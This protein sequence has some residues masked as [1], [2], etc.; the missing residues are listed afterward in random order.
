MAHSSPTQTSSNTSV[1]CA[2]GRY[3]EYCGWRMEFCVH[4]WLVLSESSN[5]L[6]AMTLLPDYILV[7][8]SSTHSY[9][10]PA[11]M[12]ASQIWATPFLRQDREMGNAL[13]K[14]LLTELKRIRKHHSF[15]V[16]CARVRP[17]WSPCDS[18]GF[19]LQCVCTNPLPIATVPRQKSHCKLIC[20]WASGLLTANPPTFVSHGRFDTISH[21]Q[22]KVVELWAYWFQLV[23]RGPQ[24]Q[25]FRV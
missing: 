4:S 24:G 21:V 12:Y 23:C 8:G 20:N 15:M 3:F 11:S 2:T 9:A 18:T 14:W 5:S 22:T 7:S 19:A 16:R 25:T 1:W 10:I 6:R 13:Q 17:G